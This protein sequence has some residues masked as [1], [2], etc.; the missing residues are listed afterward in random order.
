MKGCV[1]SGLHSEMEAR[2]AMI[3]S[4]ALK[5]ADALCGISSNRIN[6]VVS[7]FMTGYCPSLRGF[8]CSLVD[9]GKS[10]SVLNIAPGSISNFDL[11]NAPLAGCVTDVNA[12]FFPTHLTFDKRSF[13][14]PS[15]SD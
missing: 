2:L 14:C 4:A 8:P 10:G 5:S 1:H 15:R 13:K 3:I 12:P 6:C 7:V 11:T 9:D